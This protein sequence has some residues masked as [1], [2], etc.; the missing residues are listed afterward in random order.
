MS[1]VRPSARA[2]LHAG[3]ARA[4]L[5]ERQEP[6]TVVPHLLATEPANDEMV[7]EVL[8]VAAATAVEQGVA[9]LAHSYLSRALSE[10]PPEDSLADVL[11]GLGQAEALGGRALEEACRHL[12]EAAEH[13]TD[14]AEHV[15]FGAGEEQGDR[16][17]AASNA[18]PVWVAW[19]QRSGVS[20][21]RGP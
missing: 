4:M 20:V 17:I 18:T 10:P 3:A 21:R 15:S 19:V 16:V 13:T 12:E 14:P 11:A 6:A 2:Q 1:C 9:D 8:R 5:A 7:V